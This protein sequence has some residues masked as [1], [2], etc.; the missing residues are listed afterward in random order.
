MK[1]P[2]RRREATASDGDEGLGQLLARSR[3][4]HRVGQSELARRLGMSAANLSRIEHGSDF[5][6]STLL[7]IA[8]ELKLEPILVPKLNVPMVRAILRAS[9]H[10]DDEP[11]E[12]GRFT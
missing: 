3:R 2:S 1:A 12:R 10:A 4:E 6:V 5:R 8:R 7:D 9:E 11:I